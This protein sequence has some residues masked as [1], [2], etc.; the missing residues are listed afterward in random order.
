MAYRARREGEQATPHA[1]ER[2]HHRKPFRPRAR[3][4]V[5]S[6][7]LSFFNFISKYLYPLLRAREK[8]ELTLP[9]VRELDTRPTLRSRGALPSVRA[10]PRRH[11]PGWRRGGRP[12]VGGGWPARGLLSSRSPQTLAAGRRGERAGVA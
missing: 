9:P 5:R 6:N 12:I 10:H 11:L 2:S 8:T 1:R 7:F 4:F 3:Q